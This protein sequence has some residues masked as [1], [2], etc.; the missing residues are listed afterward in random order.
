[1]SWCTSGQDTYLVTMHWWND[2][3]LSEGIT[4]YFQYI[5]ADLADPSFHSMEIHFVHNVQVAMLKDYYYINLKVLAPDENQVNSESDINSM[6]RV[7]FEKGACM[8]AMMKAF[9]GPEPFMRGLL[10]YLKERSYKAATQDQLWAHLQ[11][12]MPKESGV[13]SIKEIM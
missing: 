4:N 5:V 6:V 13:A 11:K 12:E 1:M 9:M 3:W 7:A 10:N 2:L 8:V